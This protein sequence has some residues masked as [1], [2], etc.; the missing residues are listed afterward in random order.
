VKERVLIRRP[1][2]EESMKQ[3]DAMR[4]DWNERA[5]ADAF[6]YIASWRKN[7]DEESFFQSGEEDYRRLVAPVLDRLHFQ[8]QGKVMLEL[9]CGAGRMTRSFGQRFGRV[10]AI[11]ISSEMLRH[12]Q[13]LLPGAPNI[14]LT[15]GNGNDLSCVGDG[16][17]DF[18]FSYIVLHHMPARDLAL[19]YIR[20]ILRVLNIGGLFLFQFSTLRTP[21]M[22]W[23]GR[24]AWRVVDLPYSLG[25]RSV[26]RGI[27]SVLGLPVELA[28]KSWRGTTLDLAMVHGTVTAAGG[29]VEEVT[30][31][32]SAMTW[33]AGRKL[34]MPGK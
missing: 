31:E 17:A 33:F 12:A 21:T 24:M 16:T 3:V 25:L 13:A 29:L 18:A 7:W 14:E 23:K 22:N 2:R 10:Y 8:P 32:D 5:R 27:T 9:G 11:D 20:E 30:G 1:G 26:S 28:G 34:R 19:R 4:Q 15:L 6:H